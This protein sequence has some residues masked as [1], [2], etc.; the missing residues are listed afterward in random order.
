[1]NI[2]RFL[3][4]DLIRLEMTTD[5]EP[6]EESN[7][8]DRWRQEGKERILDE[9]VGLLESGYRT[10][11]RTKLL[12]DFINRE[13]KA[14]TAIGDGIAVPHI[15]SKQAKEFMIAFARS[16]GGYDFDSPDG[17][18]VHMFIIMAAPPYDDALYLKVFKALAGMLRYES[19]RKELMEANHPGELLRAIRAME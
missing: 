2:S 14:T 4:E 13:K 5:I 16:T 8:E 6:L 7:N 19:F 3:T 10:G 9:L 11:N 15:R 18:P 17:R 12:L 1:M